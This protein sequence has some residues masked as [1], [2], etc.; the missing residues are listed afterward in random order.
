MAL[1]RTDAARLLMAAAGVAGRESDQLWNSRLMALPRHGGVSSPKSMTEV[2][3]FY[4]GHIGGVKG[5]RNW[6]RLDHEHGWATGP[7]TNTY[8]YGRTGIEVHLIELAVGMESWTNL[9]KKLGRAW[10][11]PH[12]LRK[13]TGR[14]HQLEARSVIRIRSP[15]V[16]A[17][18]VSNREFKSSLLQARRG[19]RHR[20]AAVAIY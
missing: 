4:L 13:K 18:S 2:P 14:L 20:G 11:Q 5:L 7:I 3:L 16:T 15:A 17:H 1:R 9:H 12:R 8:R 19:V 6:I 10:A